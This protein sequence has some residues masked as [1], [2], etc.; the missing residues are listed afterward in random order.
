MTIGLS[1]KI[2]LQTPTCINIVHSDSYNCVLEIKSYKWNEMKKLWQSFTEEDKY[3]ESVFQSPLSYHRRIKWRPS[4]RQ[5]PRQR[6]NKEHR[7]WQITCL[8][9][10]YGRKFIWKIGRQVLC[11]SFNIVRRKKYDLCNNNSVNGYFITLDMLEIYKW[12]RQHE[13]TLIY[14]GIVC[15]LWHL[16]CCKT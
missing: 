8:F 10:R 11:C 13:N 12:T 6:G 2:P 3:M 16:Q 4:K 15:T 1:S 7:K 5:N 14:L 9:L